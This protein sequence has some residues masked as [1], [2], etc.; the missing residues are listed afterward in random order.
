[1]LWSTART[2]GSWQPMRMMMMMASPMPRM[3]AALKRML[4]M[5]RR[6]KDREEVLAL[7]RASEGW[8]ACTAAAD[9]TV[10]LYRLT[11]MHYC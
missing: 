8:A 4:P 11:M 10:V 3:P 9:D 1:L 7:Q 6:R 2:S 5:T